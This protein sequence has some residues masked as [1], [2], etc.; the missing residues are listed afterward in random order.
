MLLI[1]A[2]FISEGRTFRNGW[3]RLRDGV[4][5]AFGSA[6]H[7][8]P[9]A[10]QSV[11]DLGGATVMPGFID[12]HVHGAVGHDVMDASPEGLRQMARFFAS[13]GVTGFLPTTLTDSRENTLAAL[14]A[15]REA[16]AQPTGGAR[17]LGAHLEGPYL[18]RAKG[19]AQ[20]LDHIRPCV[21]QEARDFLE[22]GV[23]KLVSVAPE[24]E[25]NGWLID[26]CRK[27]GITASMAHTNATFAEAMDGIGLG[28]T[29]ATHTFN[30]MSPLH[31]RDAGAVGAALLSPHVRCELICDGVHV[32]PSAAEV[33]WRMKGRD[34]VVL[35]TDAMRATGMPDGEY[36]LGTTPAF[37]QGETA[38][39]ADGTLAGSVLTFD[40]G[41]RLF[42]RVIDPD[43]AR[44]DLLADL[45]AV[46]SANAAQAIGAESGIY[47]HSP[48]DLVVLDADWHVLYTIVQGEIVHDAK[49]APTP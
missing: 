6:P 15:I 7:P 44:P 28:I 2:Q 33:L 24:I 11:L 46:T 41:L 42:K 20:H 49:H 10:G 36:T 27:R 13:R 30:A 31:H 38:T 47:Y 21:P 9:L 34:G 16:M 14:H 12:V 43:G 39:L 5:A 40:R 29:H 8:T 35:I 1:N 48:A 45:V 32:S 3:L 19:G 23:V 26:E 22:V 4:V 25:G 18:N 17:I 37:K